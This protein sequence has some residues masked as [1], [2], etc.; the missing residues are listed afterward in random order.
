[1][2]FKIIIGKRTFGKYTYYIPLVC[3]PV[4]SEAKLRG[5]YKNSKIS[6]NFTY[7]YTFVYVH[8]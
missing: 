5:A 6:R 1:M 2:I 3:L 8:V 4:K 7:V